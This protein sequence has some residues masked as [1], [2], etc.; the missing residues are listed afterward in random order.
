M[1]QG[2][3]KDDFREQNISDAD[4]NPTN[5]QTIPTGNIDEAIDNPVVNLSN[6][7]EPLIKPTDS[8]ITRHLASVWEYDSI[9]HGRLIPLRQQ[10]SK[11]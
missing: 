10:P 5:Q 8:E 6:V 1:V 3:S 4:N 11:F 2:A 7:A 9:P